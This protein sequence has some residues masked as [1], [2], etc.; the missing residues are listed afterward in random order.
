MTWREEAR[1]A[2]RWLYRA[3]FTRGFGEAFCRNN[4]QIHHANAKAKAWLSVFG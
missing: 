4:A 3:T 1:I 2:G